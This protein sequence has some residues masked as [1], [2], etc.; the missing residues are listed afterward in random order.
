MGE[1]CISFAALVL[2]R[3]REQLELD[4]PKRKFFFVKAICFDIP[5]D[6]FWTSVRRETRANKIAGS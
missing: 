4:L 5:T 6:I 3:K 2:N 1:H